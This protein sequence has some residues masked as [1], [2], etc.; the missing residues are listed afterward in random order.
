[1]KK[2][3]SDRLEEAILILIGHKESILKKYALKE[4]DYRGQRF[5]DFENNLLGFDEILSLTKPKVI[6]EVDERF[7]KSGADI[8]VTNTAKA[9]RHFLKDYGLEDITYE[10]NLASAKIAR[11]KVS[12]YS[13][14][15][16][17]K[18]RYAAGCVASLPESLEFNYMQR[19]YAEQIKSLL[20]GKIDLIIFHKMNNTQSLKAGLSALNSILEKRKKSFEVFI[21]IDNDELLEWIENDNLITE[22]NNVKVI[23]VGTYHSN[24]DSL[25]QFSAKT[26]YKILALIDLENNNS[27]DFYVDETKKI[28]EKKIMNIVVYNANIRPATIEKVAKFL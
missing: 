10:L 25:E 19:V 24:S 9:N 18:P 13:S 16:R 28:A 5:A 11:D 26:K 12:K 14:I 15:T 3:I 20:A 17:N 7:L 21:T 6:S 8:V 22:Y 4:R 27:E 2:N 1:M 23:A